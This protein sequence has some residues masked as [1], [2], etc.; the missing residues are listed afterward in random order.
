MSH[1]VI[2]DGVGTGSLQ[3]VDA[4][5]RAW[6][7]AVSEAEEQHT[8]R[9]N[10]DAYI[11]YADVTPT[12]DN[13]IFF[14]M[15]NTDTRD[16]IIQWYRIW[17]A[18]S[19]EAIDL[20]RGQTGTPV[21]G[22]AANVSNANFGSTKTPI[23]TFQEGVDITG[24]SGGAIFDRLRISGD[25]NDVVERYPGGIILPQGAVLTAQALNGAIALEFTLSF[26]YTKLGTT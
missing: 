23:G 14:Y 18:S 21:G 22:S 1:I 26:Y 10:Q 5:N 7:F 3:K 12:A 6:T 4:E 20:Y 13:D 11:V 15:Q 17:T 24:V 19:A 2:K 16:M 9:L 8:N 25:G